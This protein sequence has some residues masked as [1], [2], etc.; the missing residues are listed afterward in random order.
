MPLQLMPDTPPLRELAPL[1]RDLVAAGHLIERELIDAATLASRARERKLWAPRADLLERLDEGGAFCPVAYAPPRGAWVSWRTT[2][3]PYATDGIR[4]REEHE[5]VPWNQIFTG[6]AEPAADA[7]VEDPDNDE[8]AR[9]ARPL[10][11]EWQLLYLSEALAGWDVDVPTDILLDTERLAE[12]ATAH[13]RF[14][15][16]SR[17]NW[18]S[19]DARWLPTIK[20]LIRLQARYWPLVHG[21]GTLLIDPA[22]NDHVSALDR[23]YR[24]ATAEDVRAQLGI[25]SDEIR[26]LYEWLARR[27][28][29]TD[30]VQDLYRLLRLEPRSRRERRHGIARRTLDWLDAAVMLRRFLR[31]LTGEL[32]PDVDQIGDAPQK[33]RALRGDRRELQAALRAACLYPHKLHLVVEGPTEVRLV[34]RLFE[35]FH[36]PWEGSGIVMTDLGGDKLKGSR[37]M[38]EGF[39]I[40][41]EVIA[42]L[43]DDENEAKRITE[44][45]ARDG[46]LVEQHVK[47]WDK[48]LEEDNFSAGELIDMVRELGRHAGVKLDL[49]VATLEAE[50]AASTTGKGLASTLQRLA[51]RPDHGAV[52]FAKPD[53]AEPMAARILQDI[54]DVGGDHHAVFARRP[55]V[56]WMLAYPVQAARA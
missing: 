31:E 20:L 28:R 49:A 52:V 6:E 45:L 27:A 22:T 55:V 37:P 54:R 44:A 2:E 1:L 43:L 11:T 21:R 41:A 34:R 47:L 4:F 33:P 36:G 35:A 16:Q 9:R 32:P 29:A 46:V 10:Y 23:E 48:S 25:T 14:V 42:L 13:R 7:E 51:R 26:A 15:E 18:A 38:L 40:Y 19:R 56:E 50:H 5:F 12:W 24:T 53:L 8:I 39:A 17:M 3:L 30:P